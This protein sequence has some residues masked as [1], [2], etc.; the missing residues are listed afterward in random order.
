[1]VTG[2]KYY[3]EG[4]EETYYDQINIFK[5]L[6][7]SEILKNAISHIYILRIILEYYSEEHVHI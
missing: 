1:M 6:I 5:L 2:Y 7:A 4:A 3:Q